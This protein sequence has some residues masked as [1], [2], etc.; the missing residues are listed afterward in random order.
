M[1]QKL[2]GIEVPGDEL[3][4][5]PTNFWPAFSG[6]SEVGKVTDAV[7][8]PRLE[9]NIGYVWVPIELAGPGNDIEIL[10]QGG[11][12]TAGQTADIP[13]LDPKKAVPAA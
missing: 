9:K 2:V 13:F 1:S 5:D 4:F 11:E 10:W 3:T 7:W 8:S 6:G 12:K